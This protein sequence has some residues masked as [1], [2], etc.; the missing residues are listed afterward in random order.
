MRGSTR[1]EVVD[2]GRRPDKDKLVIE[3]VES[4]LRNA[5]EECDDLNMRREELIQQ[6]NKLSI[7]ALY[8]VTFAIS[9]PELEA[10]RA[11]GEQV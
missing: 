10:R 1:W 2:D 9:N 3:C 11:N 5:S 6:M 7:A 8:C 4:I